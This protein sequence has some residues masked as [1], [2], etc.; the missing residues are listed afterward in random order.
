M[1]LAYFDA[2]AGVSGDM[3]LGSLVDAGLG[4]TGLR[5]VL[6][7]LNLSG[8][9]LAAEETRRGGFRACQVMVQV[10]EDHG[11]SH[12]HARK[13]ADIFALIDGSEL[14]PKVK[15]R[16]GQVFRR[17][18][19]A[20][21]RAHG[22]PL[23]EIHLH[24]VGAVDALVDVVGSVGGLAALGVDRI[25]FSPLR[26]GFGTIH[27]AHGLL[28]VPAPAVAELT[29]GVPVYAGEIEGE[30]VT[31]TG[32]ALA[33]TLAEG[34]GPLPPMVP[35]AVGL[36]A[37]SAERPLP[38]VLRLF[39]GEESSVESDLLAELFVLEANLDDMNPEFYDHLCARLFAAGALDVWLTPIQMKKG[40]PG[41]KLSTLVE[42]AQRESIRDLIFAESTT[43][44]LRESRTMRHALRRKTFPVLVQG[45]T[46]I[47]KIGWLGNRAVQA[48]PEYEDCL[49]AAR[50]LD[51]PLK[52]IYQ[53][54]A[55][56]AWDKIGEN[57][58]GRDGWRE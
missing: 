3:I 45:E 42:P 2:N 27:C 17:L 33:T 1:R 28:P 29:R 24:E 54:A 26:L 5:Q 46:I 19:E 49:K 38:N 37:G 41:T 53:Q 51:L 22:K 35:Q 32:A 58:G 56:K 43:L 21:A 23:D 8:Y 47:I 13:L 9:E 57:P 40:R 36:G 7:G 31:P 16:A 50:K 44:G 6:S 48:A 15:K 55:A 34:F 39:L 18:G 25:V 52:Q 4:L 12:A 30:M 10:A 20:E 11:Y 14:D